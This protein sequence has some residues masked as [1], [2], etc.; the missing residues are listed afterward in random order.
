MQ[1]LPTEKLKLRN[2]RQVPSFTSQRGMDRVWAVPENGLYIVD[3]TD[4]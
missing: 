2:M 1:I 3:H 4:C